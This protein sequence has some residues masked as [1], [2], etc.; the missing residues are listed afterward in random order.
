[1]TPEERERWDDMLE[2]RD[3]EQT[4]VS[5]CAEKY[6][7]TADTETRAREGWLDGWHAAHERYDKLNDVL[8]ERYQKR[9]Q[10]RSYLQQPGEVGMVVGACKGVS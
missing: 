6:R 10:D 7:K 3:E 8:P 5:H 9:L 2:F 1:M 4:I